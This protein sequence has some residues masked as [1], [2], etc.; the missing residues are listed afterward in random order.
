MFY[1]FI[2]VKTRSKDHFLW[3][4]EM[5]T[6]AEPRLIPIKTH[7]EPRLIPIKTHA[8]PRLIPIK[9][10]AEPRLI[11]IKIIEMVELLDNGL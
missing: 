4:L 11:P 2:I 8:E 1:Q 9:T 6:H 7:A 10:H 5:K 3:F